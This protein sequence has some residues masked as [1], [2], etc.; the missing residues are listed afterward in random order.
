MKPPGIPAA[1]AL[2]IGAAPLILAQ[3]GGRIYLDPSQPIEARIAD[4]I[5]QM[6]LEEKAAQLNHLSSRNDRLHIPAWGGWNQT[7]HGVWSKQPTTLFPTA[8]AMSATWDPALVKTIADSMSDEARALYNIGADGPRSKHGLVYRSPV[9]NISR[10]PRWGRI[11]ECFG[12]D[13]YLAGRV[14]VAYVQGLQGSHPKYLKVASTLKHFAVNNVETNRHSLS[15]TV[16]ERILMEYWLPHW[17]AGI[18][19]GRA[20]SVMASYNQ[21]NGVPNIANK[22]LLTDILR[23][24]WKFDGFVVSDLGGIGSSLVQGA[25]IT[26]KT[27]VAAA[28]ALEAGCDLDDNFYEASLPVA[29]RAGLVSEAVVNQALTRVLRVAFRLGAFDPPEMVPFSKI[30]PDVIESQPHRDLALKTALESIVLLRNKNG[31]LPLDRTRLKSVAVIGPQADHFE[32]GNYFGA[33]PR[34]VSPVEGIRAKLGPAVKVEYAPGSDILEPA[35]SADIEQAAGL[36]RKSDLAILFLGTNLKVEAE[37][38]DRQSLDLPG[39]QE[40]LLEAVCQANPKTV[41]V[42]MSG[43]P[44][45]VKWASANIPAILAAWYPGEEAGTALASVL[46]GDY[47]PAGRLPYTVYDSVDQIPPQD[48][49]DITRGFTYLYFTGKPQFAFGHGLS[50]TTFRYTGLKISPAQVSADGKVTVSVDVQNTGARAGYEVVQLYVH[51]A[52]ASVKRPI[53]EL[54]GFQRISLDPKEKRS[55]TFTLPAADLAFY[56]VK[57]K[58]FVVE[59]GAFDIMVGSSSEDIR[60]RDKLLVK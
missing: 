42:I 23:G 58:Q 22:Y 53:K 33:K 39:P 26:D 20:Q 14:A 60:L 49:Y 55:V 27:E 1:L 45:S 59:P 4:L 15:A 57:T 36:A 6:T 47:N 8:I 38:R 19:E 12:E 37:G 24:L 5:S 25:H 2:W 41:A 16:P 46:F 50:Y 31:F 35:K 11:Q 28:R 7:L 51:A 56:D 52:E 43:G 44:V 40:Q 54:R 10:D 48:E 9:I 18:V 13:P 3:S 32:T 29:V 34:I 17:K 21:L 30:G